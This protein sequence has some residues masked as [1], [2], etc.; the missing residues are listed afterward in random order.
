MYEGV[1]WLK[2]QMKQKTIAKTKQM[3]FFFK[4]SFSSG[5]RQTGKPN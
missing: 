5:Q 2:L 3:F 4:H 1:T